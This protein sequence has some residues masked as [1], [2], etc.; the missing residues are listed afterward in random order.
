VIKTWTCLSLLHP[1][2]LDSLEGR[3]VY[4]GDWHSLIDCMMG[5]PPP[6]VENNY[7]FRWAL[8]HESRLDVAFVAIPGLVMRSALY[9]IWNV[10][11]QPGEQCEKL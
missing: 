9:V 10:L 3:I 4:R 8:V 5:G 11:V 1:L 2:K 7:V 6:S